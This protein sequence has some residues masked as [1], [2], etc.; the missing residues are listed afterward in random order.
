MGSS[1]GE[2]KVIPGINPKGIK[3]VK[4][5]CVNQISPEKAKL[6][7]GMQPGDLQGACMGPALL[8]QIFF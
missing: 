8:F 2:R 1:R 5:E 4:Q 3:N 7:Q 6:R